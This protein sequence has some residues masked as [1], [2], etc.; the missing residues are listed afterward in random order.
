MHE[1]AVM[2]SL[3][4]RYSELNFRLE[5][6]PR[7]LLILIG[8]AIKQPGL[9]A[10]SIFRTSHSRSMSVSSWADSLDQLKSDLTAHPMRIAAHQNMPFAIGFLVTLLLGFMAGAAMG[11]IISAVAP[12]SDRA[13]SM[14]PNLLILQFIFSGAVLKIG[15]HVGKQLPL[16]RKIHSIKARIGDRWRTDVQVN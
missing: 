13:Q 2:K 14:V 5:N 15:K 8:L 6:F 12:S 9:S 1:R 7:I 16:G 4:K 3:R 11:L 10:A